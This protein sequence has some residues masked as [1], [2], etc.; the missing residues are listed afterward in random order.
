MSTVVESVDVAV[1]VRTAY[2]QWTMFEQ[3]PQF[4]EGVTEVRQVDDTRLHWVID[5]AG[6]HREFDAEITE[7]HPDERV[8]WTSVDGPRHA[9]VVT[10]HRLDENNTRVTAQMEI[11]PDGLVEQV[12]TKTGVVDMRIKGD[13]KRFREYIESRGQEAGGWRGDVDRPLP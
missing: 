3:F 11:D 9:G 12:G 8:A 7:Q 2:N 10:F 4:M 5:I 1:P 6:V 13:M